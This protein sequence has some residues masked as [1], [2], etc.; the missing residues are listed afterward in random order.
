MSKI[1]VHNVTKGYEKGLARFRNSD[2]HVPQNKKLILHFLKDCELGKTIK[3]HQ[4]KK[5]GPGRCLKYLLI[6]SQLSRWLNKEFDR[7]REKDMEH[8]ISNLEKDSYRKKDGKTYS[9][10]TK[11]DF[12]KALKKFYKWLYGDN[13]HY[14]ELVDWI[15]TYVKEK[16]IPALS[17]E[18]VEKMIEQTPNI[19]NKTIIMVLF[20]SGCRIEECL[21]ITL[22][23]LTKKEDYF[24]VRIVYSK[25]K[26]R[27][28]SLPMST[29][30]IEDWL[31]VHPEKN[32]PEAQLFPIKYP[33]LRKSLQ[34][35]GKKALNK[36]VNPHLFRHSSATYYANKLTY[37]QLCYRYGWSMSSR[38]P[39]R[40][41]DR[42]G[43]QEQQTARIIKSDEVSSVKEENK[44]IKED[45]TRLRAQFNEIND[46]MLPLVKDPKLL[47]VL[48]K[49]IGEEGLAE[50]VR[51]I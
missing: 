17:R 36:P 16:E 31:S 10:E 11:A 40:Y 35:R 41:I 45:L 23:D 28:I 29:K 18:E 8:L 27:T 47:G 46:L 6:L 21:N 51:Q 22:K 37:F 2:F 43:I 44:E 13:E 38:Q 14:P 1:D 12:K 26:P 34:R 15:D 20:D 5:I 9:E 25:T 19:R 39:A 4:K 33:A 48:L 50:K 24:L 42:A 7:V 3:H 49:K 32:N 30:L